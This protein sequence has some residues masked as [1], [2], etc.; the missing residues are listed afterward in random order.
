[1]DCLFYTIFLERGN[2]AIDLVKILVNER[3]YLQVGEMRLWDRDGL[4]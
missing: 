4:P 1:M 3:P 2:G